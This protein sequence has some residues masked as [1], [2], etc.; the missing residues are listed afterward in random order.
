MEQCQN[1][2]AHDHTNVFIQDHGEVQL[3]TSAKFQ[4]ASAARGNGHD[5]AGGITA[6]SDGVEDKPLPLHW[7][8]A[9]APAPGEAIKVR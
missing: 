7:T 9:K 8:Q 5:S 2:V 3:Q 6:A 4:R 1:D